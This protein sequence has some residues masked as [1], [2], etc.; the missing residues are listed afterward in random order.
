MMSSSEV[1]KNRRHVE[2]DQNFHSIK[3]QTSC[4][5]RLDGPDD[6]MLHVITL[7]VAW[8]N[9]HIEALWHEVDSIVTRWV[10]SLVI[11]CFFNGVI[12]VTPISL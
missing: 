8:L 5:D 3:H 1:L 2:V 9:R 6:Q 10:P 11:K 4:Q 7:Q 12:V